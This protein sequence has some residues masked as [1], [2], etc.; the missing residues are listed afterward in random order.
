[1]NGRAL[2]KTKS[3]VYTDPIWVFSDNNDCFHIHLSKIVATSLKMKVKILIS[4][5]NPDLDTFL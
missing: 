3:K 1:M 5:H 4:N 2:M